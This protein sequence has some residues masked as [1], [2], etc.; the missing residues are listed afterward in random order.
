[1]EFHGHIHGIAQLLANQAQGFEALPHLG[2]RDV[3]A[4]RFARNR[5]ERPY[6]HGVNAG[7]CQIPRQFHRLGQEIDMVVTSVVST[8]GLARGAA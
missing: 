7:A 3:L 8:D 1:M 4:S 6:F 2:R 5:I